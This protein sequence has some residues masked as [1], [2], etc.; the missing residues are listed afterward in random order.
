MRTT[1]QI[2]DDLLQAAKSI[3]AAENRTVGQVVSAMI[4]KALHIKEYRDDVEDIPAFRVSENA[5][6]LTPEMV[7][8]ADEDSFL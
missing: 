8:E 4:R 5:P 3:A 7:R 2:D 6:P 1:L